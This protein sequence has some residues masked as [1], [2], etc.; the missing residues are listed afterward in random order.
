[1]TDE[2]FATAFASA[3]QA[4]E[5]GRPGYP[6]A[7]IDELVRALRLQRRSIVVDLAAGT[8]KLTRDLTLRFDRVTA[9]EPSP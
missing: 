5:R 1:M 6:A 9:I 4:Y 8:G 3:A 7:A 2:Q